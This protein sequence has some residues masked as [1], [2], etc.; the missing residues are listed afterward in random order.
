MPRRVI[1]PLVFEDLGLDQRDARPME[2]NDT[3]QPT[4]SVMTGRRGNRQWPVELNDDG[5][6]KVSNPSNVGVMGSEGELLAQESIHNRL[7][8]ELGDPNSNS[9]VKVNDNSTGWNDYD[10]ALCVGGYELEEIR[11]I[12]DDCLDPMTSALRVDQIT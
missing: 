4:F 5:E 9:S 12:L 10:K 8:V 3:I 2:L 1:D 6:V 11:Y 7:T